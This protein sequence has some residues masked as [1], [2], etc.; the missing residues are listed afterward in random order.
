M[1]NNIGGT[2][3]QNER[4]HFVRKRV[5]TSKPAR[6]SA[7]VII[8]TDEMDWALGRE[9]TDSIEK[10]VTPAQ[11]KSCNIELDKNQIKVTLASFESANKVIEALNN[12]TV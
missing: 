4:K 3:V 7:I 8:S 2:V 1:N 9:L 6:K 10:I 11:I 12:T 5:N